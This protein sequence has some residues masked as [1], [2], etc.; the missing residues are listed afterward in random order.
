MAN[1]GHGGDA[2]VADLDHDELA[3]IEIA[4]SFI[5]VESGETTRIEVEQK[6]AANN[7]VQPWKD[8]RIP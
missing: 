4:L 5:G 7:G 8:K 3:S 6:D 1:I 2:P